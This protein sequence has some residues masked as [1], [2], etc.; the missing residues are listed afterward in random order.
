M[1]ANGLQFNGVYQAEP[2]EHSDYSFILRF[3]EDGTVIG[4]S[5]F[6]EPAEYKEWFDKSNSK[7]ARG[8]YAVD[9]DSLE[10][11]LFLGGQGWVE[12]EGAIKDEILELHV[13]SRINDNEATREYSFLAW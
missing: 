6:A 5:T 1:A 7:M 2:D 4:M 13:T 9:G 3:F 8:E 10:F 12:Y 11:R